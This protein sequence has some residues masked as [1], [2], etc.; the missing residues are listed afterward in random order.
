MRS[1]LLDGYQIAVKQLPK[2]ANP[3]P[4]GGSVYSPPPFYILEPKLSKSQFSAP[5]ERMIS[6]L[7]RT[8]DIPNGYDICVADDIR[9]AYV[10]V[11]YATK[12]NK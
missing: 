10:G 6:V 7:Y 11:A 5:S 1:I 3:I 12:Y 2:P 4:K 8:D 9:Y